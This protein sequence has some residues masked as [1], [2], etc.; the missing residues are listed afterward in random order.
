MWA[1]LQQSS[2][3]LFGA[4]LIATQLS[5]TKLRASPRTP[6][7]GSEPS[8]N[9]VLAHGSPLQARRPRRPDLFAVGAKAS[10]TVEAFCQALKVASPP[11]PAESPGPGHALLWRR[12][13]GDPPQIVAVHPPAGKSER[14]TRKYVE[15]ELGEDKSF[16]FRGPDNALN[17]RAQNLSIF[18]QM[19]DGVDDA[20]WLYHLKRSDYSRWISEAIKDEELAAEAREA[21]GMTD[22]AD[23]RRRLQ[24]SADILRRRR[25]GRTGPRFDT[26]AI[27]RA[28]FNRAR[29]RD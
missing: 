20:T 13:K 23:S 26:E 6:R 7:A 1:F 25:K 17:L 16:Y 21:E 12:A 14:H 4:N 11:L 2:A 10:E 19:A 15:G 28:R 27:P 9:T 8:R 5:I 3:S 22:P 24:R 18:N 29:A